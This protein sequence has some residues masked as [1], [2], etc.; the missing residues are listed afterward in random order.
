MRECAVSEWSS[1]RGSQSGMSHPTFASS[2]RVTAAVAGEIAAIAQLPEPARRDLLAAVATGMRLLAM[3]PT[4]LTAVDVDRIRAGVRALAAAGLS[5]AEFIRC[6]EM[7]ASRAVAI[8]CRD[9]DLTRPDAFVKTL[10][11]A[12]RH[13]RE[14]SPELL[15]LFLDES[16][17]RSGVPAAAQVARALLDGSLTPNLAAACGLPR[18]VDGY[19]VA[20]LPGVPEVVG[21]LA[22]RGRRDLLWHHDRGELVLL[23]PVTGAAAGVDAARSR[24]S[25]A[26]RALLP[27]VGVPAVGVFRPQRQVADAVRES[28]RLRPF[29]VAAD[30]AEVLHAPEDLAVD[31]GVA[32]LPE[33]AAGL[34]AV[35]TP[36][37]AG[38][39]L[40]RTLR[41][42]YRVD[43]HRARAAELLGVHRQTL[44]YRL[45][46]IRE[47]TGVDPLSVRGVA[48]LAAAL[49]AEAE[50]RRP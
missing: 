24:I 35:L 8:R 27:M 28:R 18:P 2:A 4:P 23:T 7:C 40:R 16:A 22:E 13:W 38:T 47:L 42:L 19:L 49:A 44:T 9:A 21:P 45:N 39:E 43:L 15:G 46:R 32:R 25:D 34:R 1:G 14:L 17:V 6:Q 41:T 33:V 48:V 50:D 5:L 26:L 30:L 11:R 12:G 37:G 20:A 10:H 31:R 29:A 3:D 36:L